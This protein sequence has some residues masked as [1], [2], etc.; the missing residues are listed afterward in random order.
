METLRKIRKSRGWSL[1]ELAE[2]AGV[3][4]DTVFQAERGN[5]KPNTRTVEKLAAALGVSIETLLVEPVEDY[6]AAGLQGMGGLTLEEVIA[7]FRSRSARWEELKELEA[8]LPEDSTERLTVEFERKQAH[9]GVLDAMSEIL[10][11]PES[12]IKQPDEGNLS[13]GEV[14]VSFSTIS[15]DDTSPGAGAGK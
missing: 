5:R 1:R 14:V 3:A 9:A 2:R 12:R 10:M 4:V 15:A 11:R 13:T 6:R 7:I 8:S